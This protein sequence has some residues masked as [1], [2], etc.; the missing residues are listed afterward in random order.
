MLLIVF[1]L[2]MLLR[3]APAAALSPSPS[4]ATPSQAVPSPM[5]PLQPAATPSVDPSDPNAQ[6][7]LHFEAGR[8]A[9]ARGERDEAERELTA[10]L[11]IAAHEDP[12]G[13]AMAVSLNAIAVLY[14]DRQRWEDAAPFLDQA[15]QIFEKQKLSE[16]EHFARLLC[17]RGDLERGRAHHADAE[18]YFRR[19]LSIQPLAKATRERALRGLVA[20][21]CA[22]GRTEEA[23]ML[24]AEL[25]IVCRPPK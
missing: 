16:S 20:A 19:A 18:A 10:A 7:K 9:H 1:V 17:T 5:T 11:A 21:I 15:M 2:T 3:G 23:S 25:H 13:I 4:Q 12:P 8:A 22:Q 14:I 6:W 24:G